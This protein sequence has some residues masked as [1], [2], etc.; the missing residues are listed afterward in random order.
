M[1][2][3][4]TDSRLTTFYHKA[5]GTMFTPMGSGTSLPRLES[6]FLYFLAMFPWMSGV[7]LISFNSPIY[8]EEIIIIDPTL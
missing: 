5:M 1:Y 3:E 2:F 7:T 8:K 6:Q 4:G